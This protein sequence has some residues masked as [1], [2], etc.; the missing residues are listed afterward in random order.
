MTIANYITAFITPEQPLLN[1]INHEQNERPD[2]QPNVGLEAGRLL[3]FLI[4]LLNAKRVLEFGTCLGYS[5]I[6][7]A[8]AIKETGGK[9]TSIELNPDLVKRAREYLHQAGLTEQAEVI[10]GDAAQIAKTLD[11]PYDLILQDTAKDLYP[12][13]LKDCI[14]LLRPGGVLVADDALFTPMGIPE[15]FSAPV[16]RLN[17]AAFADPRLYCTLLP[18]GDGL[19]LCVKQPLST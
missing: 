5:A 7:M 14:R 12:E 15:K 6:W 10:R 2:T 18:V 11:G 17:E 19:L 13:M 9:L 1:Q 4:R 3:A 16:H 8:E